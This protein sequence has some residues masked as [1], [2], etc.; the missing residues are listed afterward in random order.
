MASC[1]EDNWVVESESV[2]NGSVLDGLRVHAYRIGAVQTHHS[3]QE[4]RG[5]G[6][7]RPIRRARA[8]EDRLRGRDERSKGAVR[9]PSHTQPTPRLVSLGHAA[10]EIR[11]TTGRP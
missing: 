3:V 8:Q 10:K 4:S 2:T 1:S 5:H 9:R 6:D 7:Q 11:K